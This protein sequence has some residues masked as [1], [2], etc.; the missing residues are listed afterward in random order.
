MVGD[1]VDAV[2]LENGGKHQ[3]RLHH[4]KVATNTDARPAPEGD[5]GVAV[6]ICG[7]IGRK[8]VWV[9]SLSS[10]LYI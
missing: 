7:A 8:A 9:K 3:L 5:V 2:A 4:R 10:T 1:E 6:A